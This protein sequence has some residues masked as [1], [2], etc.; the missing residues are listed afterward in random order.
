[1]EESLQDPALLSASRVV[2]WEGGTG[3]AVLCA[4]CRTLSL[5]SESAAD[6]VG[7]V[8]GRLDAIWPAE[9]GH[10]APA[11]LVAAAARHVVTPRAGFLVHA[12]HATGAT[13]DPPQCDPIQRPQP[14]LRGALQCPHIGVVAA[15]RAALV[16]LAAVGEAGQPPT[17]A[18]AQ[19]GRGVATAVELPGP[20]ALVGAPT[21]IWERLTRTG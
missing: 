11:E 3:S 16:P 9:G 8:P 1:V 19:Y 18:A 17:L 10:A 7:L 2:P 21:K 14:L 13:G 4:Q 5:C 15:A 12:V 6:S 20:A